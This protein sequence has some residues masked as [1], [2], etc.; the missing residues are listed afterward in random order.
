[1]FAKSWMKWMA[2]ATVPA[3]ALAVLPVAGQ[4]RT[5]YATM[6]VTPPAAVTKTISHKKSKNFAATHKSAKSLASTHKKAV[7]HR[8][9]TAK[10]GKHSVSKLTKSHKTTM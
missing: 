3:L 4:A 1:M 7:S 9:L 10:S 6:S 5:H 2:V 8:K